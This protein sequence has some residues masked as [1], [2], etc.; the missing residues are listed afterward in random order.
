[1]P[2]WLRFVIIAVF[3]LHFATPKAWADDEAKAKAKA[4][5]LI[6]KGDKLLSRGDNFM[7]RGRADKAL[8]LWEGALESYTEAYEAYQSPQIYFLIAIAEQKLGRNLDAMHHY[9]VMLKDSENLNPEAVQQ[10]EEGIREVRK[11][12]VVLD[13]TVDQDGAL[14]TVD[15]EELGRTP[16][17]GPHYMSPGAHSFT[18]VLEGF[19]TYEEEFDLDPGDS[20]T[21]QLTMDSLST[22]PTKGEKTKKKDPIVTVPATEEPTKLPMQ[23]A[24]GV[25]GVFLTAAIVTGVKA[26]SQHSRYEDTNLSVGQREAAR[27]S[28]KKYRL[29][30][31]LLA[32]AGALAGGYGAYYYFKTYKPEKESTETALWLSPYATDTDVGVAFGANF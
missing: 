4:S 26:N 17:D 1:M 8:N 18:V 30:T 29:A 28:G 22:E 20:E 12:L 7:N 3:T 5:K 19:A 13:L 25:S 11:T 21:R 32:V 14:V 23:I 6:G 15:G 16:L 10:A 9:E 27:T 24:F 31:D 2:S